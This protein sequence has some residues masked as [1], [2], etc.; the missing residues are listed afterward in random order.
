MTSAY[1]SVWRLLVATLFLFA[2][3]LYLQLA[4]KSQGHHQASHIFYA[5]F[6]VLFPCFLGKKVFFSNLV[7]GYTFMNGG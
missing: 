1:D 7:F 4:Q 6:L 2:F 5:N 3:C